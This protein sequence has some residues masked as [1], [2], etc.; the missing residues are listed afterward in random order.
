MRFRG[1]VKRGPNKEGKELAQKARGRKAKHSSKQL[2]KRRMMQAA[3]MVRIE[4]IWTQLWGKQSLQKNFCETGGDL[5]LGKIL[6]L[7]EKIKLGKDCIENGEKNWKKNGP[8]AGKIA[9][10]RNFSC[11][12]P[13]FFPIFFSIF[14][15][16]FPQFYFF[17]QF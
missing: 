6:K 12:W 8:K 13:V 10:R 1:E 14:Y 17:N 9:P 7:I 15:T 2:K 16:I 4:L 5:F 3:L 11:F